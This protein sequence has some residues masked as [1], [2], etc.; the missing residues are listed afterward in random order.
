MSLTEYVLR[1]VTWTYGAI[2]LAFASYLALRNGEIGRKSTAEES[3]AQAKGTQSF[4]YCTSS[5]SV[6]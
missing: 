1:A 4:P 6:H 5:N 2:A 3:E